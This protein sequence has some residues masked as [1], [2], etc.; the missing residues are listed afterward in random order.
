MDQIYIPKK[1][2]ELEVGSYVLVKNLENIEA[3][4]RESFKANFYNSDSIEKIKLYIIEKIFSIINN[5]AEIEN[6]IITGS[7]LNKGFSFE[8]LDILI[9]SNRKV[10]SGHLSKKINSKLGI[11]A[12][13][14]LIDNRSLI[15]GLETDP[16]YQLMLSKCVSQK[17]LI[18]KVKNKPNYKIL[19]LHLLKSKLLIDNFKILS[20][21]EKYALTRNLIAI[22]LFLEN[23]K[24][25]NQKIEKDIENSLRISVKDLKDNIINEKSFIRLYENIYDK[26]SQ[27]ILEGIKDGSK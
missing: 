11:N 27:K 1:R 20:G 24:L 10:D 25:I 4:K 18:Y 8:D 15:K 17:R 23:E 7:F 5:S 21:N 6:I 13:I 14:L 22:K 2:S 16:L 26:I 12:H 19:D 9:V 3:V